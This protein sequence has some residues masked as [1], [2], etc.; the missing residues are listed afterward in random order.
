MIQRMSRF[1][2]R[3]GTD[4]VAGLVAQEGNIAETF[5]CLSAFLDQTSIIS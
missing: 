3:V 1:L 2:E 4:R 5:D